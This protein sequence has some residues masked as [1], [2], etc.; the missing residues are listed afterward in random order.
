MARTLILG[1]GFGGLTVATELRNSL[2]GEHEI[3]L[4]DSRESFSMG[5]RKLWEAVGLG[6]IADGSRSREPLN[7]RGIR[8]IRAEITAIDPAGRTATI[9]DEVL[10]GDH[11]VV[12]LGAETRPDLVEGLEQHGH[13]AWDKKNIPAI[14]EAL[15]GFERGRILIAIAGAPYGC[16]PAP[17][18]LSMLLE[19]MLRERGIRDQVEIAVSTPAPI[20]LPAAGS[21]GSTF[22]AE[23]LDAKDI[24]YAVGH[25]VDHVE[26]GRVIYA[27][28]ELE[29][30][31]LLSVPPHRVPRVV[32]ESGLTADEAG[33]VG[34][35]PGT[36]ETEFQ[37]VFAIGDVNQ[38]ELANGLPLPMAGLFAELQGERVAAAIAAEIRGNA[39]PDAF[40]GRGHCFLEM[41]STAAALVQGDFFAD[42]APAVSVTKPTEA[43]A[44]EKRR[45]ES[46]RLERWFGS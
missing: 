23:Q 1:A 26:A 11:I 20:L 40:A 5:L 24:S 29:Y 32:A 14:R 38:I 43:H 19:E 4:V 9:G 33:W 44:A 37:G 45:F 3:V 21:E 15:A 46:E 13:D 27:D 42:P 35:D 2:P 36:L 10:E 6:T 34:V 17:Y 7:E 12:A 31:L 8:F 41:D 18:E 30:D 28:G 16:P 22:L 25:K 39:A